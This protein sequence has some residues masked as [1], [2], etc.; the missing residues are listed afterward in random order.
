MLMRIAANENETAAKLTRPTDQTSGF[1]NRGLK[2]SFRLLINKNA[3]MPITNNS[4][5]PTY[6]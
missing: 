6:M 2:M 4:C 3:G 5:R 1:L